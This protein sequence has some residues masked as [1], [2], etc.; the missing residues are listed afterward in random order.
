[1]SNI[2]INC[3]AY[4]ISG[5][6]SLLHKKPE[7][8]K[9]KQ[10]P[11]H[12]LQEDQLQRVEQAMQHLQPLPQRG[13]QLQALQFEEP[14]EK[15]GD[16]PLDRA[17]KRQQSEAILVNEDDDHCENKFSNKL[18]QDSMSS[19][20][21]VIISNDS[22]DNKNDNAEYHQ[23]CQPEIYIDDE[24]VDIESLITSDDYIDIESLMIGDDYDEEQ[25]DLKQEN[26]NMTVDLMTRDLEVNN[27]QDI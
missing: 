20:E 18:V 23:T 25:A 8:R 10:H 7:C 19:P 26:K 15:L 27:F 3:R 1:M 6:D 9:G 4:S 11:Q 12:L 21:D 13:N 17:P 2:F 16:Q 14:I 22:G 5:M 24:V